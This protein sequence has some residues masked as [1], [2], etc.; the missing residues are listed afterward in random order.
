[1]DYRNAAGGAVHRT[2]A[3][4]VATDQGLR[5]YMLQVYNWMA[6]GLVLTGAVA[7]A[8]TSVDTLSDLFYETVRTSRGLRTKLTILG[9]VALLA[10]VGIAF[11]WGVI[12]RASAAVVQGFYWLFAGIMGCALAPIVAVYTGASIAK[13]FFISAATF[14]AMSLY[15]YTTKRDLTGF[16]NFLLMGLIGI[17]IAAIVNFFLQSSAVSFAISILGVLIFVGLTAYDTQKIKEEYDASDSGEIAAKKGIMGALT[18][19]LDFIN[20]FLLLL[21][22][23]GIRRDE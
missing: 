12:N 3:T 19:Y 9:W 5:D 15:G 21:Q 23:L 17:F 10:P 14:G 11:L 8:V 22:L 1:M 20:I 4:T 6:L 13:V 16:G 18:L 2:G 7:F